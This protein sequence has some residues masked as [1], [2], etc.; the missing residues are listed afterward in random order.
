MIQNIRT[1]EI[2]SPVLELTQGNHKRRRVNYSSNLDNDLSPDSFPTMKKYNFSTGNKTIEDM[3]YLEDLNK[4]VKNLT[5]EIS[6]L[7]AASTVSSPQVERSS[8]WRSMMRSFVKKLTPWKTR[9]ILQDQ[10]NEQQTSSLGLSSDV[11]TPLR[12]SFSSGTRL[13]END[14]QHICSS[15]Y[16]TLRKYGIPLSDHDVIKLILKEILIL[17]K[18]ENRPVEYKG[19][20][21]MEKYV[22]VPVSQSSKS[23]CDKRRTGWIEESLEHIVSTKA[24]LTKDDAAK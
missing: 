19:N 11:S 2:H 7:R 15:K 6:I 10:L 8:G 12:S 22:H 4:D 1:P 16:P 23:F 17:H 18:K 9:S 3:K 14:N 21:Y 20:Q 5:N 24:T 13:F